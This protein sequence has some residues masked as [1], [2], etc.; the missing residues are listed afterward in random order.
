MAQKLT[1]TAPNRYPGIFRT[2]RARIAETRGPDLGG[3]ELRILSFGCSAGFEMLSL[4]AYFPDA[5]IFGCDQSPDA[6]DRAR[7]NLREDAGIVFYSTPEAVAAFGPYDMILAMSVLC[8]Y[9]ASSK[10]ERL[11][12][13]FPFE[14]YEG[15]AG[16]LVT[17]L[18]PGGL[19]SIFNANYLVRSLPEAGL[20]TPLRSPLIHTNG[21]VDKFAP[22]GSRLTTSIRDKATIAHKAVASDITDA[23]LRDCIYEKSAAGAPISVDFLAKGPAPDARFGEA[24]VAAGIATETA[25]A[26]GLV[27]SCRMERAGATADGRHI[28]ESE[29]RKTTLGGS[30]EG[31]GTWW[32]TASP[33][34]AG[35]RTPAQEQALA[36]TKEK[37]RRPDVLLDRLRSRLPF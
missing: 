24:R 36:A 16:Q 28:I 25:L 12:K 26:G 8:Q 15:L 27:A 5:T 10:V 18:R 19:I 20:L 31:F 17:Q 34:R 35:K 4:R 33:E 13:L 3:G 30:V 6:L 2:M 9:P 11:D 29:W 7:R 14:I 37:T 32:T 21:F 23:D 1:N 22:D